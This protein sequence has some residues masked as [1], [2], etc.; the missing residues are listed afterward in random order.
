MQISIDNSTL[1]KTRKQKYHLT[2]ALN[3]NKDYKID[4]QG[5]KDEPVGTVLWNQAE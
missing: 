2:A 4:F 1:F 3:N 5:K